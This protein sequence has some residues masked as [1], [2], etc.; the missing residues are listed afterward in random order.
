MPE[1]SSASAAISSTVAL[2]KP[3]LEKTFLAAIDLLMGI[4]MEGIIR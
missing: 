3:F 2:P 4:Q 1:L